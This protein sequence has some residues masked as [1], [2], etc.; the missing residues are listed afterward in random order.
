M[1]ISN[2]NQTKIMRRGER[3]GDQTVNENEKMRE[4]GEVAH[5]QTQDKKLER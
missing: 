2:E 3:E 4:I 1:K 5:L